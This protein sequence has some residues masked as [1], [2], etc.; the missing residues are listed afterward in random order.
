MITTARYGLNPASAVENT[1]T[2]T[3]FSFALSGSANAKHCCAI[4][5]SLRNRVRFPPCCTTSTLSKP[6]RFCRNLTYG[7]PDSI[8]TRLILPDVNTSP[9]D[10]TPLALWTI[11]ACGLVWYTA[12]SATRSASLSRARRISPA[13]AIANGTA[14]VATIFQV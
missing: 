6:Y 9:S 10:V 8:A 11:S 4:V 3:P 13:S 14:P 5:G 1:L 7:S 2:S 12:Y